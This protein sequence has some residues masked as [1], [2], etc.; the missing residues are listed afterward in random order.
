MSLEANISMWKTT[1]EAK[2]NHGKFSSIDTTYANNY[3]YHGAG[4][5]L[6]VGAKTMKQGMARLRKGFSD[7]RITN[8]MFGSED[9]AVNHFVIEGVQDGAWA[10]IAPTGNRVKYTGIAISQFSDGELVKEWEF[11]D[12]LT[13]LK[14][15][16]IIEGDTEN[17]HSILALLRKIKT[18]DVKFLG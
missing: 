11:Y 10:G 18:N 6:L 16:G 4:G 5:L 14:Q 7:I 13:L 1:V 15:L 2:I 9:R 12:E 3:A 8:D 17:I